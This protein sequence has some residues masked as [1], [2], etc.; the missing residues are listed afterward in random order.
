MNHVFFDSIEEM[1]LGV[2]IWPLCG[3]D[4]VNDFGCEEFIFF[5]E[6]D[7]E[8]HVGKSPFLK[9]NDINMGDTYTENTVFQNCIKQCLLLQLKDS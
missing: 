5:L 3:N 6:K 9:F 2:W 8:V 1:G 7:Q 4:G